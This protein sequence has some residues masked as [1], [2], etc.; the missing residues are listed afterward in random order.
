LFSPWQ[1]PSS[2]PCRTGEEQDLIEHRR[3]RFRHRQCDW[4]AG[5]FAC[6]GTE[7]LHVLFDHVRKFDR[8]RCRSLGVDHRHS[9]TPPPAARNA[10][11]T[12]LADEFG[13]DA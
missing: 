7:F 4:L 1:R 11:S 2:T 3:N 10:S 8:S 13:A 12:S 6:D 9:R 5:V